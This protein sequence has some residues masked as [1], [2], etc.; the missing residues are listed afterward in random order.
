MGNVATV[1]NFY[2]KNKPIFEKTNPHLVWNADESLHTSS[3]KFKVLVG[4][5]INVYESKKRFSHCT[6]I[7]QP[8]DVGEAASLKPK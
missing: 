4:K 5:D 3:R 7:L 1:R 6:H 8:F 2:R